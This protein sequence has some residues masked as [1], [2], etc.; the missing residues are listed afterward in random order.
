VEVP[1]GS[2]G[3]VIAEWS[4]LT[5]LWTNEGGVASM[6]EPDIDA[7]PVR[8]ESN[9]PYPP[10]MIQS[11]KLREEGDV[12]H[13]RCNSERGLSRKGIG[14]PAIRGPQRRR[15]TTVGEMGPLVPPPMT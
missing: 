5:A 3:S 14:V 7:V 11:Q 12:A 15:G 6:D 2:G 13:G 8:V 9:A 4:G 1:P 10:G